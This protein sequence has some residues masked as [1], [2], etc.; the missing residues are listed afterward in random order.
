LKDEADM[1][2]DS[3]LIAGE[4][5]RSLNEQLGDPSLKSSTRILILIL[6]TMNKKMSSVELRALTGLGKGSLENHLEK[7]E[8][9]GFVRM[10]NVKSFGGIHQT[11][12]ITEKGL[13]SCRTLLR[14]IQS[15]DV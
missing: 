1:R 8:A 12:E 6:L 7:L 4:T 5:I 11:V 2:E 13:E 9:A 3:G 10:R 15:L 14:R